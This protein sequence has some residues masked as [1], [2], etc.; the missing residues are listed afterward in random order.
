MAQMEENC[1]CSGKNLDRFLQVA[2]LNEL[3][4]EN[5]HGFVLIQRV[6]Q[7]PMFHGE[8]PDPT[9]LYRYLKKMENNDLLAS[10]LELWQN[11]SSRRVYWITPQGRECFKKWRQSIIAYRDDLSA[12]IQTMDDTLAQPPKETG[13]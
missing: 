9:G 11:S 2:I 13:R 8:T 7:S 1:A 12:L 6:A 4:H 3:Y 10:R 5:L